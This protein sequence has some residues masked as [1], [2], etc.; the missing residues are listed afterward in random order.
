MEENIKAPLIDLRGIYKIYYMGDEEV[1]ANDG[2]S[3]TI[4]KGNL[5]PLW[6]SQAAESPP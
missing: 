3:L 1:R 4:E 2:I 6:E 5:W